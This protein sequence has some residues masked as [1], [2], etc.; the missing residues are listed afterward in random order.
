MGGED[1]AL[2]A[3]VDGLAVERVDG[4][5]QPAVAVAVKPDVLADGDEGDD[6][7]GGGEGTAEAVS[8]RVAF[9][10]G[11]R[12]LHGSGAGGEGGIGV[13]VVTYEEA[14]EVAGDG[15]RGS[16]AVG[17][18]GVVSGLVGHGEGEVGGEGGGFRH[19]TEEGVADG[20]VVAFVPSDASGCLGGGGAPVDPH[21]V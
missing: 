13:V 8:R 7:A 15:G 3:D 14:G 2:T 16:D 4:A 19:D 5:A 20:A 1:L 9:H 17:A 18:R 12:R 11:T 10:G 6:G 21:R